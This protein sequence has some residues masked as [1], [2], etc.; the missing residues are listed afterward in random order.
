M[1]KDFDSYYNE[2]DVCAIKWFEPFVEPQIIDE[3]NKGAIAPGMNIL[4]VGSGC[5]MDSVF[6]ASKGLNVT[7]L[8][9]APKALDKLRS[10]TDVLGVKINVVCASILDVPNDLEKG[11]DVISDN[12]CFH[13]ISPVDRPE[14][15]KSVAQLLKDNGILYI[16]AHSDLNIKSSGSSILRANRLSSDDI[17]STFITLFRVEEISIFDYV[18]TPRGR[19]KMWF[20]KLRLR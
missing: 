19:E 13:H 2:C 11:F 7:A 18:L 5:S 15:A 10:I 17:I 14:Y 12:G 9:F 3:Y 8:D 6:F 16:R 20:I 4:D 1:Q